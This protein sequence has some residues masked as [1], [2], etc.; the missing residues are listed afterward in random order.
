MRDDDNMEDS[1]SKRR[2]NASEEASLK[3]ANQILQQELEEW[4]NSNKYPNS[5]SG[6][7]DA[8]SDSTTYSSLNSQ[9]EYGD[10]V[11]YAIK[12]SLK[13]QDKVILK[14]QAERGEA[15]EKVSDNLS[16]DSEGD[17]SSD[18][19]QDPPKGSPFGGD[20]SSGGN[21]DPPKPPKPPAGEGGAGGG[22]NRG[23]DDYFLE[24]TGP[25]I[26]DYED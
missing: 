8:G 11:R 19:N 7:S 18:G 1:E 17:N 5:P 12:L 10:P 6:S 21:Q 22:D 13:E 23:S 20:N 25:S 16:K 24:D 2:A 14:E 3:L 15:K 26:Y 4:E 9:D